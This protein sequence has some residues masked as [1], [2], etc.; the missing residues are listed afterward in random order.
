VV[1][2]MN[3][4]KAPS[5]NGFPMAFFH[6]CWDVI[7]TYI[8]GVFSDFHAHSKFVKSLN[9]YFHCSNPKDFWGD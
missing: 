6:D 3:R 4:D 2:G 8:M 5:S 1:K 9:A 7:R